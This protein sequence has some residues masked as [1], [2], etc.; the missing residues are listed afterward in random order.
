MPETLLPR[1]ERLR[2]TFKRHFRFERIEFALAFEA[3][4]ILED[5]GAGIAIRIVNSRIHCD[6]QPLR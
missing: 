1:G 3:K 4:L 6:N 5:G 2:R